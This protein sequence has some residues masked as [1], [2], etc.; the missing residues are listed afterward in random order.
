MSTIS[1]RRRKAKTL[2]PDVTITLLYNMCYRPRK[3]EDEVVHIRH[4]Q[5]KQYGGQNEPRAFIQ[6]P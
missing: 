2:G 6:F 4:K 1:F 5:T 3:G